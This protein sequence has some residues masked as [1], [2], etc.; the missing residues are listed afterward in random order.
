MKKLVFLFLLLASCGKDVKVT[1]SGG[2]SPA[3]PTP[4]PNLPT[5]LTLSA[6][7]NGGEVK[8]Q[9]QVTSDKNFVIFL[10]DETTITV[11]D[12]FAV[13]SDGQNKRNLTKLSIGK[14]VIK[15]A[16][17]P[18]SK[19]VA[20][21]ADIANTGRFDL[22]TINVNDTDQSS[23][24]RVNA[25]LAA[26][27]NSIVEDN[28]V[29]TQ[30]SSRLVFASDEITP[31]VRNIYVTQANVQSV[32]LKINAASPA[33]KDFS[34][35]RNNNR[36]VY[37]TATSNPELHS[38]LL[39]GIDDLML[40]APFNLQ[41]V[42]SAGISGFKISPTSNT[43]IYRTNQYNGSNSD[44]Y[45]S[46]INNT[47][48]K[49]KLNGSLVTGGAV[50]LYDFSPDGSKIAYS[51]DQ[52]VDELFQIYAAS[53]PTSSGAY[54]APTVALN[55]TTTINQEIS[56]IKFSSDNQTVFY[57][58]DQGVMGLQE[59]YSAAINGSGN[60][61][62][63]TFTSTD[64]PPQYL[65][66]GSRVVYFMQE[67][68]SAV[69]NVFSNNFLGSQSQERQ[70]S[71]DSSGAGIGFY[72]GTAEELLTFQDKIIFVGSPDSGVP[73]AYAANVDGSAVTQLT[74][75]GIRLNTTVPYS[76]GLTANYLVYRSGN[77]L[78][79]TLIRR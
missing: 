29:W 73:Q 75:T 44:L 79:I 61:R 78:Y 38:V 16:I 18:D 1:G 54:T 62:I 69:Y 35:A 59:L 63:N 25:G 21:L 8:E 3:G 26:N 37:R 9:F 14:D 64:I 74:T 36:V 11:D 70:I 10:S 45:L 31:G 53:V 55:N 7:T 19:K 49:I 65:V 48:S 68:A 66:V 58:S 39:S 42:P 15:F 12:L 52:S 72:S 60:Y 77:G 43:V 34:L 71:P 13:S 24:I 67:A 2:G 23:L 17:S 56:A 76:F 57:I 27:G 28:F 47:G 33:L 50:E 51:A 46:N 30:D 40:N 20:F 22:Y 6:P 32:P 41:T 5:T 4:G